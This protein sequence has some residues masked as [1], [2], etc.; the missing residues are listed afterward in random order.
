VFVCVCVCVCACVCVSVCVREGR[1]G[2]LLGGLLLV[3]GCFWCCGE[4]VLY[5]YLCVLGVDHLIVEN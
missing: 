1:E 3:L 2:V 5:L 4:W